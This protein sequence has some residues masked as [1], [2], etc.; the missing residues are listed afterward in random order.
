MFPWLAYFPTWWSDH[1]LKGSS[2]SKWYA[3]PCGGLSLSV[4]CREADLEM[5]QYSGHS[6]RIGVATSTAVV[7]DPGPPHQDPR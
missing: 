6:L 3:S 1:L 5:N 7:E 4:D 2:L